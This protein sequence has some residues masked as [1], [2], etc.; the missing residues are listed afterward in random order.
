MN[1]DGLSTVSTTPVTTLDA[2]EQVKR[3]KII[4]QKLWAI[5]GLKMACD[6]LRNL[7]Y[8]VVAQ[9]ENGRTTISIELKIDF[10]FNT[11]MIGG[12]DIVV[13]QTE[14]KQKIDALEGKNEQA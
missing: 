12:K 5:L 1:N 7:G 4:Q 9:Q 2:K 8:D 14:L 13:A 11:G 6:R 3:L 10:D